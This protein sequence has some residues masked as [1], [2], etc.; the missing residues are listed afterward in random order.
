MQQ[1]FEFEKNEVKRIG[2]AGEVNRDMV[3]KM[4]RLVVLHLRMGRGRIFEVCQVMWDWDL[5]L[6]LVQG[7]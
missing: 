1:F 4:T 3:E 5:S 2:W 7:E 6:Q